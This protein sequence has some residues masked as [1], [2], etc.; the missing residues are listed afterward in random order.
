MQWWW[1]VVEQQLPEVVVVGDGGDAV[2][3]LWLFKM[4]SLVC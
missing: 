1:K 4:K 2:G 3:W